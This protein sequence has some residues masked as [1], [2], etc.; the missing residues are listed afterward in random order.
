MKKDRSTD[1]LLRH[2]RELVEALDRRMPQIER[3]GE[4][5][6]AQDARALRE[7]AMARLEELEKP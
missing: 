2:L 1:M 3:S 7:S 5:R 6:I 4:A